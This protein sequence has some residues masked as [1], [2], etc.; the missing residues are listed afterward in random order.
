M[1]RG[2]MVDQVADRV[3][4]QIAS[5]QVRAG[6]TLPSIRRLAAEHDVNPST[7]QQVLSRLHAAGFVEPR[8]GLG[9]VVRDVRADG[10]IE[11]WRYLFRFSRRLPDLAVRSVQ[12]LLEMLQVFYAATLAKIMADQGAHDAAPARRAWRQLELLVGEG[13]TTPARVHQGVMQILRSASA[14]TGAGIGIGLIN[15]LGGLLAEVPEVLEAVYAD[16]GAHLWWWGELITAWETTDEALGRQLIALL[17]DWHAETVDRV[18]A[19][20][21]AQPV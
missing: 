15:S 7:V 6:E 8:H 13:D 11:T 3:A 18:R 12:E 21:T 4:F 2:T 5:G 16:P 1:A 10:G 17:D 20:L 19:L 9:V 14:A